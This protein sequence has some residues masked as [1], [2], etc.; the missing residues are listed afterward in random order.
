MV[1]CFQNE[2]CLYFNAYLENVKESLA[3]QKI[4]IFH[5][6]T[7]FHPAEICYLLQHLKERERAT[8]KKMV[9]RNK[10]EFFGWCRKGLD[11]KAHFLICAIHLQTFKYLLRSLKGERQEGSYTIV[12][13]IL[14]LLHF[15]A[16]CAVVKLLM[17]LHLTAGD[18]HQELCSHLHFEQ[19][20]MQ[21]RSPP[22]DIILF[23]CFVI[24]SFSKILFASSQRDSDAVFSSLF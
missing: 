18:R 14:F 15:T 3:E 21:G 24:Q 4:P 23:S 9:L 7:R 16:I 12:E 2:T 5:P 10:W 1:W 6:S 13:S 8:D 11:S 22:P 19:N 20:W 17:A